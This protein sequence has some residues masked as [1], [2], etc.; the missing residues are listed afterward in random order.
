MFPSL[1]LSD[2]FGCVFWI[3]VIIQVENLGL[4]A[5]SKILSSTFHSK[6]N[7]TCDCPLLRFKTPGGR[8]QQ[9]APRTQPPACFAVGVRFFVCCIQ[10]TLQ[11]ASL[12]SVHRAFSE[13]LLWFVSMRFGKLQSCQFEV[14]LV[15][16]RVFS[17]FS[18]GSQQYSPCVYSIRKHLECIA[19]LKEIH[20]EKNVC[21]LN[22]FLRLP[23][24]LCF[25]LSRR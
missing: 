7:L 18:D 16:T 13:Q 12:S 14:K 5:E 15:A 2:I 20:H 23:L 8:C 22:A 10:M 1:V 9:A 17:F 11:K 19:H 3:P 6:D 4:A 24:P 25:S 21:T